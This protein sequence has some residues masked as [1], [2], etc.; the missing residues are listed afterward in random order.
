MDVDS[1]CRAF[2][3]DDEGFHYLNDE[4]VEIGGLTFYGAEWCSDFWGDPLHYYYER[5]IADF[6]LTRDWSTTRHVEECRRV[7]ENMATQSGKV[8]VVITHFPPTLE[9][10]DQALYKDSALNPYFINDCDWLVR[11]ARSRHSE[12]PAIPTPRSITGWATHASSSTLAVTRK[13]RP[14]R[15]FRDDRRWRSEMAILI[16]IGY[17]DAHSAI[18]TTS[19]SRSS[20]DG[21]TW[22]Q[23]SSRRTRPGDLLIL[24]GDITDGKTDYG[25]TF[26]RAG[27]GHLS[28]HRSRAREPRILLCRHKA[29]SG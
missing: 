18:S 27:T 7:T 14:V 23:T 6:W 9:A 12:C 20:A 11:C 2:A 4:T 10:I 28:G 22:V 29:E 24:A 19:G 5:E 17:P 15:V 8:D 3:G 1:F 13:R 25:L 16:C 21:W 26:I